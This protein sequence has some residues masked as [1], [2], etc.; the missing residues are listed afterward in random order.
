M[1]MR[2]WAAA[3]RPN[4]SYPPRPASR[5]AF[6][7]PRITIMT[8]GGGFPENGHMRGGSRPLRIEQFDRRVAAQYSPGFGATALV[9][10]V[11]LRTP[12][13]NRPRVLDRSY[14][15]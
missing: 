7:P 4:E 3:C 6:S 10:N 2:A 14:P 11:L 1:P 12:R 8:A 13:G 15:R 5:T 9:L